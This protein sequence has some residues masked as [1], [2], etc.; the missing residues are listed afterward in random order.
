MSMPATADSNAWRCSTS[1]L[2]AGVAASSKDHTCNSNNSSQQSFD[3]IHATSALPGIGNVASHRVVSPVHFA[4]ATLPG[5]RFR[6]A[7][8]ARCHSRPKPTDLAISCLSLAFHVHL[9]AL[10][11]SNSMKGPNAQ[12]ETHLGPLC[13]T[14]TVPVLTARVSCLRQRH[15]GVRVAPASTQ[16]SMVTI[17]FVSSNTSTW[18]V[19]RLSIEVAL[20]IGGQARAG[21][22]TTTSACTCKR[23]ESMGDESRG[24]NDGS[25]CLEREVG[26]IL[27]AVY[28]D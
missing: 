8:K 24:R 21:C 13:R 22:T 15:T 1:D 10:T 14:G 25:A 26:L 5:W 9:Q 12:Q 7:R 23:E 20:E 6:S 17:R 3:C 4:S 28:Y 16:R 2:S 27:D 19:S 11:G 18:V